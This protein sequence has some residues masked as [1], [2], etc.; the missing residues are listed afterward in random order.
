VEEAVLF[1]TQRKPLVDQVEV[2]LVVKK[3]PVL[4]LRQEQRILAV[5]VV[6]LFIQTLV[7]QVDQD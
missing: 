7:V 4:A 2:V 6:A 5:A 1:M 3:I